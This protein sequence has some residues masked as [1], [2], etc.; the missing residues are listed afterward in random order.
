MGNE[1]SFTKRLLL[2]MD[3]R[4]INQVKLCELTGLS[5][6]QVNH[7]AKGNTKDPKMSTA[8]KIAEA[9]DVSL[10]Y[11]AGLTDEP[12][13][14]QRDKDG[15]PAFSDT[16]RKLI[17]LYRETDERGQRTIMRAAQGAAEDFP[18]GRADEAPIDASNMIGA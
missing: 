16:E 8:C 4:G 14:I 15:K 3:S 7:L 1:T 12:R 10:D 6:A 9:L 2:L 11:F 5:S 18:N 17:G 13:P